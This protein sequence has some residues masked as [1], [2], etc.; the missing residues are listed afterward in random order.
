[1]QRKGEQMESRRL[2]TNR[3]QILT[4]CCKRCWSH[5]ALVGGKLNMDTNF[6][7]WILECC[8]WM[9]LFWVLERVSNFAPVGVVIVTRR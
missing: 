6:R 1:M 2:I 4:V 5:G 8:D 9:R 3:A 7:Y